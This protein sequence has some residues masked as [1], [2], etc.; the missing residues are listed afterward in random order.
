MV[1]VDESVFTGRTTQTHAYAPKRCNFA[2]KDQPISEK[3]VNLL[4]AITRRHG[5][6]CS[7]LTKQNLSAGVFNEFLDKLAQKMPGATILMDNAR[8]YTAKKVKTRL[9]ELGLK[10]IFLPPYSP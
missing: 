7:M 10:P 3:R 2:V 6:V 8:F 9:S 5:V 4:M 1:V